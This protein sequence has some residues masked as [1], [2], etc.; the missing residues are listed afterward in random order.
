MTIEDIKTELRDIIELSDK[1]TP[2]PWEHEPQQDSIWSGHDYDLQV[3]HTM[4]NPGA[5]MMWDDDQRHKNA[6]FIAASRNITPKMAK[7]LLTAIDWLECIHA[8]LPDGDFSAW[9]ALET[10]R[11]EWEVQA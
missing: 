7:A 9:N 1:A 11:R 6:T 2:A 8:G 3:A 4:S 5:G 10:I